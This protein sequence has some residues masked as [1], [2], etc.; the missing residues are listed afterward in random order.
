MMRTTVILFILLLSST[1]TYAQPTDSLSDSASVSLLTMLPGNEVYSQFGHS[2]YRIYDPASGRDKT[3]NYGTFDF[4]QPLFIVRFARGQLD[5]VLDTAPYELELEK[6]AYLRRPMIEQRLALS[7]ETVQTLFDLLET[8]A[9]PQN[10]AYRYDFFFDNC[11]TRLLEILDDALEV[12][13]HGRLELPSETATETFRELIA[14]Y[15]G[16]APLLRF[17]I[18]LGLG[19]PSDA[20]ATP[21]QRSFLPIELMNQFEA[22]TTDGQ[23]LVAATDT[24]VTVTEY[25]GERAVTDWPNLITWIVF[26]FGLAMT[27][28]AAMT[29]RFNSAFGRRGDAFLFTITGAAGCLI[30]VL[31]FGTEHAVTGPNLN[32]LWAW[33]THLLAAR[34]LRKA[35]IPRWMRLYLG[36][37][38]LTT[39]ATLLFWR[40]LPQALPGPAIPLIMLLTVRSFSRLFAPADSQL[41]TS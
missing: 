29:K 26:L 34:W 22:A 19:E 2:G 7:P 13:G 33:P 28:F 17:G 20:V 1:A 8:N 14:P 15:I 6:Y 24:V 40:V 18:N 4:Q 5:Y 16:D 12:S 25:D 35:T 36:A 3:Y 39:I 11:S 38:A 23:R 10:R 9:L 27:F 30:A 32:L 21:R 41:P 31:W 37:F